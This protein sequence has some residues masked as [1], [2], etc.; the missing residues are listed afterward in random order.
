MEAHV[1][2]IL[3]VHIFFLHIALQN[4]ETFFKYCIL[5]EILDKCFTRSVK[6][7]VIRTDKLQD[8]LPSLLTKP[9]IC[10][11]RKVDPTEDMICSSGICKIIKFHSV[12]PKNGTVP[13]TAK[14]LTS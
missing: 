5:P 3:P 10:Y 12:P 1:E 6:M 2:R 7:Q 13:T 14:S 9:V 11:C 4:V 8:E